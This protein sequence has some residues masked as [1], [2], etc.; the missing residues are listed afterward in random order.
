MWSHVC[1]ANTFSMC[2][3]LACLFG[4]NGCRTCPGYWKIVTSILLPSTQNVCQTHNLK[5]IVQE[6]FQWVCLKDGH[7]QI[8]WFIISFL[9]IRI[10]GYSSPIF[11][12]NFSYIMRYVPKFLNYQTW[13]DMISHNYPQLCVL[14]DKPLELVGFPTGANAHDSQHFSWTKSNQNP[15]KRTNFLHV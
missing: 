12:P 7:P 2:A 8:P 10:Y 14:V 11:W 15:T 1:S 6:L 3:V 4:W 5:V 9:R 13:R